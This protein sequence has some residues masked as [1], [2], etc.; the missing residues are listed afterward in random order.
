MADFHDLFDYIM[1]EGFRMSKSQR[2]IAQYITEHYDSAAFMTAAKLG[3]AVGVSESTV[4]RFASELGFDGFYGFKA[5][6]KDLVKNKLTS[7]QRMEIFSQKTGD[8]NVLKNVLQSDMDRLKQTMDT[9]DIKNFEKAV[10]ILVGAKNVYILGARTCF[11]LAA[12]LEVYLNILLDNVKAI[13]A[14]SS[15]DVFE[16]MYRIGRDDAI[17]AISYPRYSQRTLSG[18]KFAYERGAR[19]VAVT[20]SVSSP[21]VRYAESALIAECDIGNFVDS[22]VAPLSLINALIAAIVKRNKD[23]AVSAFESL[24]DIWDKHNAYR[25]NEEK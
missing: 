8:E 18:V 5:A 14:N 3:E 2:K 19:V 25:N 6:L 15:S 7:L 11:S 12:F 13:T 16:Q 9:V 17:V 1:P 21:I 4:V 22:L 24:E 23:R 20:D 10:D